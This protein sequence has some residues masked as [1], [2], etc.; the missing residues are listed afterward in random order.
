LNLIRVFACEPQPI[1]SEGLARVLGRSGDLEYIGSAP[2]ARESLEAVRQTRPD[3]LLVDQTGGLKA[4]FQF[5]SDVRSTWADCKP[6]LWIHEM[7]EVDCFR[8]LQVGARGILKKTMPVEAVLECM[9]SVHGGNVWIEHSIS[10]KTAGPERRLRLTPRERDIVHHVCGGLKNREIALALAITPGTVKVHLMHIFEKTGVK[11]RFELAVHG[12]RMLGADQ[13]PG[14]A[15]AAEA[16]N[17]LA[18]PAD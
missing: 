15:R 9:R 18:A 11:D 4:V 16:P 3:I 2:T 10:E 5:I 13:A 7:A 8:A 6:V 12:R 17:A 1:V 14:A